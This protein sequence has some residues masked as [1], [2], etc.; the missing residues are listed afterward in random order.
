MRALFVVMALLFVL[1]GCTQESK[2]VDVQN[3]E[4]RVVAKVNEIK[5]SDSELDTV[6]MQ[7]FGEFAAVQL[8]ES[9]REKLLE[10]IIIKKLMA[11]KQLESMSKE[12]LHDLELA[13]KIFTD[14]YLSKQYIQENVVAE[15]V[16]DEQARN[17]YEDNL[18]QYGQKI[19]RKY[20]KLS[21][22]VKNNDQSVLANFNASVDWHKEAEKQRKQGLTIS[23]S[24]GM[25][26]NKGL[27]GF[28]QN[29]ISSLEEGEVSK[30]YQLNKQFV[31]F[32]LV[33]AHK[34]APKPFNEVKAQIKK[35]LAPLQIKQAIKKEAARLT[36]KATITRYAMD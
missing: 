31:K 11:Q 30:V 5:I 36:H 34:S 26:G 14:E 3:S 7:T 4:Q 28:Y 21:L 15:P 2:Q 33:S 17:Y 9:G 16:S 24:V 25:Q 22:P 13:Q 6:L 27:N 8:G 23:Y 19:S 32:K 20:E 29:V 18:E 10:S 1:G 12:S 35:T